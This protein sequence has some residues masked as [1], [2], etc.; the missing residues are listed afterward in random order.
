[1]TA[2][3]VPRSVRLAIVDHA[4]RER[5]MECCG[6]ILGSPSRVMFVVPM[7]NVQ[8]SE[9]RYRIDDRAHIDLRRMLRD[10]RPALSII[11][12]YHSH[13]AG[14]PWP[15]ETDIAEA[16]YPDWVHVIVGLRGRRPV[17]RGF[18]IRHGRARPVRLR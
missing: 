9:V 15:S 14:D 18:R 13:P 8:R 12:V 5:P 11:G 7:A 10:V 16:S 3:S 4:R 2:L 1:V 6:F 17:L